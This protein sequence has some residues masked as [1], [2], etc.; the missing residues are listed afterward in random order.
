MSKLPPPK[1][2]APRKG[3]YIY[4]SVDIRQTPPEIVHLEKTRRAAQEKRKWSK[5]AD[6]LRV[7]RGR[8]FLYES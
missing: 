3:V 7:K 1:P 4:A 8:L 6:H 2:P 5:D